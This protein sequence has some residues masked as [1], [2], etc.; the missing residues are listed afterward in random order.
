ME[1]ASIGL[2]NMLIHQIHLRISG[3]VQGVGFRQ[4]TLFQ[5]MRLGIKG[6]V[7]NTS[8]GD[9]E[10][11]AEGPARLIQEFMDWC[12]EGPPHA[13]VSGVEILKKLEIAEMSFADFRI[14]HDS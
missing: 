13:C 4:N 12:H 5:A 6:W 14:E 1:A 9:V 2:K 11:M 8:A 10:V 3:S 7:R